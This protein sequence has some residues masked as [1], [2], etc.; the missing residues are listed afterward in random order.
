MA[1]HEASIT[2]DV[3]PNVVF[4]HLSDIEHLPNYLPRLTDVHRTEARAADAQGLEARRPNQPVHEEVEVIADEPSG[5]SVRSEAWVE[6]VEEKRKL[7][8]GVPGESAYHGELEVDF[9]ADGTSQLTVRLETSHDSD[10]SIDEE[11]HS[12]LDNI[13]TALEQ[14]P[15]P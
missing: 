1:K 12:A 5:H 4:D 3:A 13:K 6:I 7:R 8:W 15:T 14:E 9:V 11:L 10:S 2:V